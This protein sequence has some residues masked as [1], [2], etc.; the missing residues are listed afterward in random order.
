MF[1]GFSRCIIPLGTGL[2]G[3][4]KLG[5]LDSMERLPAGFK[6]RPVKVA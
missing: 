5:N 6:E 4:S 2:F 1:S 3:N